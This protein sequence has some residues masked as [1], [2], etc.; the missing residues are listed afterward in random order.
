MKK[1]LLLFSCLLFS[2]ILFAANNSVVVITLT[3]TCQ[4]ALC[5]DVGFASTDYFDHT[6]Y[7][8]GEGMPGAIYS[9]SNRY[10]QGPK[11]YF[12][13]IEIY[14]SRVNNDASCAGMFAGR[15]RTPRSGQVHAYVTAGA[16]FEPALG[17]VVNNFTDCRIEEVSE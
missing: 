8:V 16:K 14:G 9:V 4:T 7:A 6:H 3:K 11:N 17:D 1:Y 12:F 13:E 15:H 5:P 10:L 2:P